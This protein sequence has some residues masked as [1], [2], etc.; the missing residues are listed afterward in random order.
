[1]HWNWQNYNDGR[2]VLPMYLSSSTCCGTQYQRLLIK[3]H[4]LRCFPLWDV[5][6][7]SDRCMKEN[8]L[9]HP[10]KKKFWGLIFL[11]VVMMSH[12]DW[13]SLLS[14][15]PV[16]LSIFLTEQQPGRVAHFDWST[17]VISFV[18]TELMLVFFGWISCTSGKVKN[19][20]Y[21]AVFSSREENV[22]LHRRVQ[23]REAKHSEK[24]NNIHKIEN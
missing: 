5:R 22:H 11:S 4:L 6:T 17:V 7:L 18:S 23:S 14:F 13:S 9:Y 24:L 10:V 8:L 16:N 12:L 1:M 3:A 21:V 15:S 2:W 20:A 19:R